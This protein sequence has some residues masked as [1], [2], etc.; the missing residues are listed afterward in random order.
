MPS[1]RADH[2]MVNFRDEQPGA[3]DDVISV[4]SSDGAPTDCHDCLTSSGST[5]VCGY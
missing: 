1:E 2:S 4:A 5:W 3:V